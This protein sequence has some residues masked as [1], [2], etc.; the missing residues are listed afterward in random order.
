[1]I[2]TQHTRDQD[3]TI[4]IDLEQGSEEWLDMRRTKITSTDA[5]VIVGANPF[6]S[7]AQLYQDKISGNKQEITAPMQRGLDLEPLARDAF[8]IDTGLDM[9]PGVFVKGFAMASLDG[10]TRD[11][12]IAVEI[13]C[14]GERNHMI[15]ALGQVPPIYYPQLQHIMYVVGLDSI[16]YYSFAGEEGVNIVVHRDND[17]ISKMVE[18]EIEF[19]NSLTSKTPPA[20]KYIERDDDLWKHVAERYTMISQKRKEL[21]K[22]EEELKTQLISMS[23]AKNCRGYG[24]S[25]SS[26]KRKGSV[27][28]D[29]IP[30]LQ[31]IDLDKYRSEEKTMYRVNI[32]N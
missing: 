2:H 26:Y 1:M 4:K 12:K 23:D 22:E 20:D 24:V 3:E 11:G 17:Y 18:K 27:Q 29:K 25:V 14:P 19:Y 15:A 9:T 30:E 7:L 10:I 8:C 28:Y 16:Y 13:K 32:G 21:E 31:S 5:A 6:R